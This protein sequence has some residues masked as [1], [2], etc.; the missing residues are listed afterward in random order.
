MVACPWELQD[1]GRKDKHQPRREEGEVHLVEPG[2]VL[3]RTGRKSKSKLGP[4]LA[5]A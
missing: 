4:M 1:W 3:E 5:P 2:E